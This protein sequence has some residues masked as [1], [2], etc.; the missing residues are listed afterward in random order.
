[1]NHLMNARVIRVEPSTAFNF[2]R[3]SV[4]PAV[5]NHQRDDYSPKFTMRQE[6]SPL[7]GLSGT[8]STISGS[9]KGTRSVTPQGRNSRASTPNSS[10]AG[11][12]RSSG[13][14]KV[15]PPTQSTPLFLCVGTLLNTTESINLTPVVRQEAPLPNPNLPMD[16]I[17][18]TVGQL[19]DLERLKTEGHLF[20]AATPLSP[21]LRRNQRESKVRYKAAHVENWRQRKPWKWFAVQHW[22]S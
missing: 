15:L 17:K 7:P 3:R 2:K 14:V 11:T 10:R 8:K 1:M 13:D 4:S 22:G 20:V 5:A 21:A 6:N 16:R 12:P 18:R 19:T 9:G